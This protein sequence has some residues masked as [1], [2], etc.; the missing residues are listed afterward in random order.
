MLAL[1]GFQTSADSKTKK[2]DKLRRHA[3][4]GGDMEKI[5]K[6]N[7]KIDRRKSSGISVNWGKTID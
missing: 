4:A 6:E 3:N 2:G 7:V 5:R 1:R